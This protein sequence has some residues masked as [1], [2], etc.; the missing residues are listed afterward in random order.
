MISLRAAILIFLDMD[1]DGKLNETFDENPNLKYRVTVSCNDGAP[2]N[3][4]E[5]LSHANHVVAIAFV[6]RCGR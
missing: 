2:P 4:N 3:R 1:D 5:F 6:M